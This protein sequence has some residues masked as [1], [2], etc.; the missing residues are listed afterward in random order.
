[1]DERDA[2]ADV[3]EQRRRVDAADARPAASTSNRTASVAST[4]AS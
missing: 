3:A 2:V 4:S 1:M